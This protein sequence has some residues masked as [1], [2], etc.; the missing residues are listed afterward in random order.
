MKWMHILKDTYNKAHS[1]KKKIWIDPYL[2]NKF[3]GK[4]VFTS[5]IPNLDYFSGYWY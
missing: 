5:N 1:K 3:S 4:S 2:L